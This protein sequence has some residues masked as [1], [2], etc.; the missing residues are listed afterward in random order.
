MK[1][2][3][4]LSVWQTGSFESKRFTDS[5]TIKIYHILLIVDGRNR[6]SDDW[7]G[8]EWING[9]MDGCTNGRTDTWKDEWADCLIDFILLI[10]WVIDFLCLRNFLDRFFPR[11]EDRFSKSG[12]FDYGIYLEWAIL[13]DTGCTGLKFYFGPYFRYCFSS[14]RDCEDRFH[15]HF[16]NR[17]SHIWFFINLQSLIGIPFPCRV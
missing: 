1:E 15:F 3:K 16:M 8:C 17:R 13:Y 6:N 14:V 2:T 9:W 5:H 7:G 10:N 4:W 12:T 11:T